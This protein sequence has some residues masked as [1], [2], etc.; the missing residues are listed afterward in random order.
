MPHDI[1]T[2]VPTSFL[3]DGSLDVPGSR[4]ILEH[5][6]RSGNEGAFVLGTTGEFPVI[7][8]AEFATLTRLAMDTL[9]DTMRVVVHVGHPSAYGALRRLAIARDAGATE[10]AA[11]TPY[12]LPASEQG[13]VEYFSQ[14]AAAADGIALWIYIY[15]AR[16]GNAVSPALLAELATLPGVVG[17]KV[18][19]LSLEQI[20]AYRD[21]VP[22]HFVLYTGAD[23]DLVAAAGSGA[24]GV[25]SG[26]SSVLPRP[27]R[28]LADA[29]AAEDAQAIDE[30]QRQVDD[31]VSIIGG[32]MARMKVALRLLG[33]A[34]GTCRMMLDAPDAAAIGEIERVVAAYR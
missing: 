15:P 14:L 3:P 11:I 29:A 30:A 2:A 5:V 18:S 32:D 16:S 34:D 9:G 7:E 12:Y 1:L 25:V 24:Q 28:A 21:A 19:E 31:V 22:E 33:V 8:E 10:V 13:I 17:A 27:F 4:A 20:Q 26:V 6:G 23:R